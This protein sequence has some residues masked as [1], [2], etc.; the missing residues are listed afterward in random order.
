MNPP[1]AAGNGPVFAHN[2]RNEYLEQIESEIVQSLNEVQ[3]TGNDESILNV[4]ESLASHDPLK[5]Q[6][7]KSILNSGNNEHPE[8]AL[9]INKKVEFTEEPMQRAAFVSPVEGAFASRPVDLPLGDSSADDVGRP[10]PPPRI[11]KFKNNKQRLLSVPNIKY[12]KHQQSEFPMR[13]KM[14]VGHKDSLSNLVPA[15]SGPVASGGN[16]NNVGPS[17]STS[18]ANSLMRRFSKY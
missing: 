16:H 3:A 9:P 10:V 11:G 18:F 7:P 5:I 4:T 17:S 14:S 1:L 12:T 8:N 6:Q 15:G 2:D 13:G